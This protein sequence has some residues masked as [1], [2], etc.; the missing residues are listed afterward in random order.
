[1]ILNARLVIASVNKTTTSATAYTFEK[2]TIFEKGLNMEHLS[3][4]AEDLDFWGYLD[5]LSTV[6]N[7]LTMTGHEEYLDQDMYPDVGVASA[8]LS[9]YVTGLHA[10][11]YLDDDH[12]MSCIAE[13]QLFEERVRL[14]EDD[15][16]DPEDGCDW[17]TGRYD[18]D[19]A[20]GEGYYDNQGWYHSY[21]LDRD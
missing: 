5:R 11:G 10:A 20:N 4:I 19:V 13:I 18:C 9:G 15:H 21:N 14:D 1:M 12:Y 16:F 7:V 17:E 6:H 8:A 3:K 2:A